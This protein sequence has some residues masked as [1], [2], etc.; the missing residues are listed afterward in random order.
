MGGDI[1]TK[2]KKRKT[3][4]SIP[5]HLRRKRSLLKRNSSPNYSL[6]FQTLS[7]KEFINYV[8]HKPFLAIDFSRTWIFEF[9]H[10]IRRLDSIINFFHEDDLYSYFKINHSLNF[11]LDKDSYRNSIFRVIVDMSSQVLTEES[12]TLDLSSSPIKV[13]GITNYCNNSAVNFARELFYYDCY[14]YDLEKIFSKESIKKNLK[15]IHQFE[16]LPID[17]SQKSYLF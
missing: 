4:K 7:E 15:E 12:M 14:V 6:L 9:E 11:N 13:F 2:K 1:A 10:T 5:I 8:F 17:I 3:T 16:L